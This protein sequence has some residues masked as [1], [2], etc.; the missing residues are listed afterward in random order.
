MTARDIA[1]NRLLTEKDLEYLPTK[2]T[3]TEKESTD[4]SVS[5][6]HRTVISALTFSRELRE[7]ITHATRIF[8]LRVADENS[9]GM[10]ARSR[11]W[12]ESS[13]RLPNDNSSRGIHFGRPFNHWKR[14]V[15]QLHNPRQTHAGIMR[16]NGA[17]GAGNISGAGE[18]EKRGVTGGVRR[19]LFT[20][21]LIRRNGATG[22]S[23]ARYLELLPDRGQLPFRT[24]NRCNARRFIAAFHSPSP[25]VYTSATSLFCPGKQHEGVEGGG[26]TRERGCRGMRGAFSRVS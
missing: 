22:R 24:R 19:A 20:G 18:G 6:V 14:L 10:V 11:A 3:Y 21:E 17:K 8:Y 16:V 9:N 5:L 26:E 13:N 2:Y 23:I 12:S 25:R 15:R 1:I 4:I 7:D